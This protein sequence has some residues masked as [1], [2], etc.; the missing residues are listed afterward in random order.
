VVVVLDRK[1]FVS[2]LLGMPH[3]AGVIVG[4]IPHRVRPTDPA[5][6]ATHLSI[7]QRSQ[8]EMVMIWHQLE[9]VQFNFVDLQC[10]VKNALK[11]FVVRLLVKDGRSQIAAIEGMVQASG[12]VG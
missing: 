6:E 4:M 9:G 12:F 3:P 8:Y 1:T 7:D 11:R 10:F 2:L 5:H